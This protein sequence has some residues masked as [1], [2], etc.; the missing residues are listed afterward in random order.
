MHPRGKP[1]KITL[2]GA[3]QIK[4]IT[5]GKNKT[6]AHYKGVSTYLP[7]IFFPIEFF[8]FFEYS[9]LIFFFE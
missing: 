2:Q 9:L 5:G 3:N 6:R 4:K 7:I 8:L 1:K